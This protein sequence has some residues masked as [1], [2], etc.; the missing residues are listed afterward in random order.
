[1]TITKRPVANTPRARALRRDSTAAE[2]KL[3]S[4]LRSRRSSAYKFRRQFPIGPYIADFACFAHRL[5]IEL[6]GGQHA[7]QA[8]YDDARTRYLE[9]QGWRVLRF[10][11]NDALATTEGVLT[12]ILD[13]LANPLPSGEGSERMRGG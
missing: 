2:R 9:A 13:A 11:N 10:W 1:M 12:M 7:Q 8:P 6:D 3:W 4:V 5:I